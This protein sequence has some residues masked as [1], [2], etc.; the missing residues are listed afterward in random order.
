[1]K[2]EE[3][4]ANTLEEFLDGELD[5]RRAAELGAHL[6][7]CRACAAAY[8]RLLDEQATYASYERNLDVTPQALWAGV[9][10][11]ITAEESR[12]KPAAKASLFE[13]VRAWLAPAFVAPR[14]SPALTAAM[15]LLAI[16]ATALVMR[17]MNSQPVGSRELAAAPSKVTATPSSIVQ[18]PTP[19]ATPAS[20]P[21]ATQN[22]GSSGGADVQPNEREKNRKLEFARKRDAERKLVVPSNDPAQ[23]LVANQNNEILKRQRATERL[24]REAEAKYLAAIKMLSEDVNRKRTRL[25]PQVAARFDETLATIDRSIAETR[26][27]VL[28]QRNDPVAVQ[29]MLSAYAK[30][31]EVMREMAALD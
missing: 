23:I 9:A 15:M 5:A 24:V 18:Q 27:T 31:V 17:Y 1:M 21:A 8:E 12:E 26:R 6:A 25:D 22:G 30:K 11:R 16:G 20:S 3:C 28:R 29:Y 19:E 7:A 14:F 2:C 13:S 4:T 10:A